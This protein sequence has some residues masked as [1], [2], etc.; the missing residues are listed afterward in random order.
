MDEQKNVGILCVNIL[1]FYPMAGVRGIKQRS[2]ARICF[3]RLSCY[4][5]SLA[6]LAT[7]SVQ[8]MDFVINLCV[9][10]KMRVALE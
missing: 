4:L 6:N 1:I 9:C 3:T 10:L 8:S 2:R 5:I 7:G